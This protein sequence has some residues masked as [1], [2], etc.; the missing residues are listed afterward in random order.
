METKRTT[1]KY[2]TYPVKKRSD[3]FNKIQDSL[4]I[5]A[6]KF[7]KG[8]KFDK[9]IVSKK[10]N[11]FAKKFNQPYN[12]TLIKS[13]PIILLALTVIAV[14][15][16]KYLKTISMAYKAA[17]QSF[18]NTTFIGKITKIIKSYIEILSKMGKLETLEAGLF[19]LAMFTED[20]PNIY[21][22]LHNIAHLSYLSISKGFVKNINDL[23]KDVVLDIYKER[24]LNKE[25]NS[26]AEKEFNNTTQST[27]NFMK[28][29]GTPDKGL[30]K[31]KPFDNPV[32]NKYLELISN[33]KKFVPAG[34]MS[35]Q[36]RLS[37]PSSRASTNSS[38]S[39]TGRYSK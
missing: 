18:D 32:S 29:L 10:F 38:N 17:S 8:V 22:N 5:Y 25:R 30:S 21:K 24:E 15:N 6:K 26:V 31:I 12:K 33:H 28:D 4:K 23:N 27:L 3:N 2:K 20:I 13:I 1:K 39:S 35:Y 16:K 7:S 14:K 37:L 19:L 9:Q 11:N 36:K 34:P